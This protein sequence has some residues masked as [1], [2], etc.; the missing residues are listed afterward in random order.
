[1]RIFLLR[2]H[3]RE[4]HLGGV[5]RQLQLDVRQTAELL[6]RDHDVGAA[7]RTS[8]ISRAIASRRVRVVARDHDRP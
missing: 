4:D 1:M 2:R 8:P 6:S 5:Q 3:A 7:L